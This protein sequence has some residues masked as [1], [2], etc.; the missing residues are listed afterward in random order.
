MKAAG[1][2]PVAARKVILVLN[3][4]LHFVLHQATHITHFQMPAP[5][6]ESTIF[7]LS[8]LVDDAQSGTRAPSHADLSFQINQTKL[9][10]GDPYTQGQ[11][12]GKKKR[13]RGTL[14]WALE[15]SPANGETF[16][17]SLPAVL[18][19]CGGFL[20]GSPIFVGT[21]QISN[22]IVAF[23]SE[24]FTLTPN[25]E[26]MPLLLANLQGAARSDALR[27]YIRRAQRGSGDAALLIGTS[28]DLLEATAAHIL[29]ER[30]GSYSKSANFESLL[31]MAFS[32]IGLAT[33]HHL[34]EPAEPP[35][36]KAERAM[37]SLAIGINA[38][39]NKLGTGHGRPFIPQVT[40]IESK[41]SIQLMGTIAEWM[42]HAHE[43]S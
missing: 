41:A 20:P 14:N 25:G 8:Q 17:V 29:T 32:A 21:E 31:G 30:Q 43:R 28:K 4:D 36:R 15:N 27:A 9:T 13:V 23:R 12:V 19:G 38:M 34:I 16:I 6:T 11:T 22:A 10:A 37:F 42:L 40:D 5:L 39:R 33:P 24:G 3:I 1:I 26:L 35:Q 18:R 7:A 2:G